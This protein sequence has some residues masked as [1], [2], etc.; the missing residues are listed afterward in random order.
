MISSP[1][2]LRPLPKKS[3]AQLV[4]RAK[5]L[6]VAPEDYAAQLVEDGLALQREAE[7]TTTAELMA[8]VRKAAGKVDE[9]EIVRLVDR[10]R[11]D[12]YTHRPGRGKRR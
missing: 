12:H 8:P 5:D 11:R 6:G 10:A 7:S 3:M 2:R 9:G 4:A 1:L